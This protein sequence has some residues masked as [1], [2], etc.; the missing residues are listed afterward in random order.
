MENI[1]EGKTDCGRIDSMTIDGI[2]SM[3]IIDMTHKQIMVFIGAN[4]TGKTLVLVLVWV[5]TMLAM[6]YSRVGVAFKCIDILQWMLDKCFVDQD[7]TGKTGIKFTNLDIGFEL[8]DGKVIDVTANKKGELIDIP[9]PIFM[10]KNTRTYEQIISYFKTRKLLGIHGEVSITSMED[11]E[12]LSGMFK[13]YDIF[14]MERLLTR[15]KL[16]IIIRAD[17]SDKLHEMFL[18]ANSKCGKVVKM[19]Y[20][21]HKTDILYE[22]SDGNIKSV[23]TLSAGEQS[24]LNMMTAQG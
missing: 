1:N 5:I 17:I 18:G 16:G 6:I 7:W 2:A 11:I 10:S 19:T 9:M 4:G 8:K 13:L 21:D 15:L 3:N 14:F 20:D 23:N 12:K 22:D 24:M